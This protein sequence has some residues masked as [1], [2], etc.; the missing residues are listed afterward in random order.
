[1]IFEIFGDGQIEKPTLAN[2]GVSIY[3]SILSQFCI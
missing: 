2:I 1:M 3:Y